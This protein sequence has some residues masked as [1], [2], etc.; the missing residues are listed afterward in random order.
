MNNLLYGV[1]TK[2]KETPLMV[3][4]A[5]VTCFYEA[6]CR[7]TGTEGEVAKDYCRELVMKAFQDVN[8]DFDRPSKQDIELVVEKLADFS[9]NFRSQDLVEKHRGEIMSLISRIDE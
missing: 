8:G 2:A 3:R 4:D 5:L 1:D 7:D 6:H 9:G